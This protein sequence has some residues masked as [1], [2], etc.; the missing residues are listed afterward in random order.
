MPK[1]PLGVDDIEI[2]L[3]HVEYDVATIQNEVYAG[4]LVL[5]VVKAAAEATRGVPFVLEVDVGQVGDSQGGTHRILGFGGTEGWKS[6][7]DK[8]AGYYIFEKCSSFHTQM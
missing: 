5:D 8:G 3:I 2:L 7:R 6:R 4:L 1:G